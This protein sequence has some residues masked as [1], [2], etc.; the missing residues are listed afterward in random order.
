MERVE[1]LLKIHR[2]KDL[3]PWE[4]SRIHFNLLDN[5]VVD[6]Y[7]ITAPFIWHGQVYLLGRVEKRDTEHSR[8]GIFT[9]SEGEIPEDETIE[10]TAVFRNRLFTIR[11]YKEI[12]GP[13]L[14]YQDPFI[15]FIDDELVLGGVEIT[16]DE[17]GHLNY[18]TVFYKGKSFDSL[19]R[20]FEGPWGM[21]DIRLKQWTDGRILLLTRP[22]GEIGGRGKIGWTMLDALSDLSIERIWSAT[23]FEDQFHPDEWGGANEIHIL[24]HQVVVILSHIARFDEAGDRHYYATSF[25]FNIETK[26]HSRMQILAERR[27][28]EAGA[29]KRP[30]LEDVIFS[31]GLLQLDNHEAALFC[32]AGDAEAHARIIRGEFSNE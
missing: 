25:T 3:L 18:R 11:H 13:E 21:K 7:N 27:D 6:V 9:P 22:Q 19:K 10:D 15:T 12:E 2:S 28:F 24:N 5:Q 4:N 31:G 29:S 17:N 20:F 16:E 14:P 8:I 32:G 26:K 1:E 23:L 30:D